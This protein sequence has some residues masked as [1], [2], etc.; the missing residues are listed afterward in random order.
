MSGK[1]D[2][3]EFF[4]DFLGGGT[5]S[6]SAARFDPWVIT[7]TS[8]AGTPTYVRRD[9]GETA[10]A[11]A[12]GEARLTLEATNEAQNVCLSF[13]D[14]LAF[15]INSV[16]GFECRVSMLQAT[17]DA[18]TSL[19][20]GLTGDRNDTIDTIANAMLFRVIGADDVDA[21]VVESDDGTNNN[22][23]IATGQTLVN[24]YKRF[25]IDLSQGLADVRFYMDDGNGALRRVASGT[26]FDL[27]NYA[28]GLQPFFQIQKTADTNTDGVAI[29]YVHV[30]GRRL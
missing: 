4:D 14:V 28:A 19:A 22:D 5:L 13:G 7:D 26:T 24:A 27:S 30:W 18:A 10:G 6:T 17:V 12:P 11:F 29:D 1:Q 16:L 2:F 21:V 20:F 3:W 23:D 9:H 8:A 15:D 25:K